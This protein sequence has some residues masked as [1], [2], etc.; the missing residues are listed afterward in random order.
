[1]KKPAHW[2]AVGLVLCGLLVDQH[3]AH[4]LMHC[5]QALSLAF[6][7][8]RA[9]L[10]RSCIHFFN[11]LCASDFVFND[12]RVNGFFDLNVL[13]VSARSSHGRSLELRFLLR[14]EGE[15]GLGALHGIVHRLNLA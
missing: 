7:G 6:I 10:L 14:G 4:F 13:H 8:Y 11:R 5:D 12:E 2:R 3:L 15:A 9:D 1:M